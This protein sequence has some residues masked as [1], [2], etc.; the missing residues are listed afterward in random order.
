MTLQT[1]F[2]VKWS[3]VPTLCIIWASLYNL[4]LRMKS[5]YLLKHGFSKCDQYMGHLHHCYPGSLLKCRFLGQLNQTLSGRGWRTES[6]LPSSL[7]NSRAL[8]LVHSCVKG[9]SAWFIT[10]DY[11]TYSIIFIVNQYFYLAL[12]ECKTLSWGIKGL[13]RWSGGMSALQAFTIQLEG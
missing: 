10:F 1:K 7:V 8:K 11:S 9:T 5:V 4:T 3:S 13:Q 2:S 6:V 12:M